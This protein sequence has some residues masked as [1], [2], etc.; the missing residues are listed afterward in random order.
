[1][2]TKTEE[3]GGKSSGAFTKL[4]SVGKV[5]LMAGAAGA[6]AVGFEAVKSAMSF[7]TL[8]TQLVTGAGESEDAIK[9]VSA[10]LLKMAPAVGIGPD[11]LAKSMFTVESAGY[12]A[13][14]GLKVMQAAAEGAKIGGADAT[15]VANGLTTAMTDYHIP[16]DQAAATT[17]KLI[18]TVA[19]GKTT[20]GDLSSSLSAVLPS[21]SA[22]HV[23]MEQVLGAMATMTGEGISAQQSAQDLNAT[24]SALGNPSAVASKAMAQMGINST[25]LAANLG[26]KGLTGTMDELQQ[27]VMQHMGPAGLVLQSSFNQSKLAAQSAQSMLT[28]LPASL[29]KV[30]QGFLNGTVTQKE[31]M[32]DLKGQPALVSNLGRQFATTAKSATGFS[33]QLKSGKGSAATF[34]AIM[35]QMTGGQ[36]GLSTSLALTGG[37]M[38]TFQANVASVGGATTEAGNHVKG[39]STTTKDLSFQLEQAKAWIQAMLIQIGEKLIPI[40]ENV[41][42]VG[43]QWTKWFEKHK[44]VL[45]AIGIVIGTVLV[46]AIAAYVWSCLQAAWATL[47]MLA[48][49]ILVIAALAAVG[50]AVY[51]LYTHWSSI[52]GEIKHIASEACDWVIGVFNKVWSFLKEWGP[53]IL[54]VLLPF[55]GLPLLI[56]QHWGA[57]S[58]FFEGIWGDITGAFSGAVSWLEKIGE[59]IMSGLLA[60]IKTIWNL[61][62]DFYV[63]L[64][65]KIFGWFTGA[66]KWLGQ[67]GQDIMSGLWNG[68][69][70]IWNR[71]VTGFENIASTVEGWFSGAETW[72]INA[73]ENIIKGIING[74]GNMAGAVASKIKS[75]VG[76]IP[77]ASTVLG[78]IGVPGFA[79]GGIVTKPTFAML[80]EGGE[81]EVVIPF[82]K[83]AKPGANGTKSLDGLL[84]N[85]SVAPASPSASGTVINQNW[86][87]QVTHPLASSEEVFNAVQ[88]A[89]L[90]HGS[91][92]SQ[93]YQPYVRR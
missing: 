64:P 18:A 34:N 6:A 26:K 78:A 75:V 19:A 36:S 90:Q 37:N 61:I 81:S 20:M 55:I 68:I 65:E 5:A 40:I 22:A 71:E 56:M 16:A 79:K 60:G 58:K 52:W 74:I 3:A 86:T 24:I 2:A 25:D 76:D 14:D 31:W 13:G 9:G 10:G 43:E 88:S 82:S 48:P 62:V 23:G 33:D 59:D 84:G 44:P 49:W 87:V 8:T 70:A 83:L 41:I 28:Q 73:G 89:F 15:V 92:N 21:A 47:T 38:A 29:Q 66:I 27:A 91:V 80:G 77:G 63:K 72:L 42:K 35:A 57:I 1:M 85:G 53:L 32:A 93:S 51:E 67:I 12:H 46:A 7:Q 30:A 4:A 45:I 50:V 69:K 17:S 54:S 39:W 11:A